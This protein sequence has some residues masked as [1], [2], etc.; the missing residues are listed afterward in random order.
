MEVATEIYSLIDLYQH[1]PESAFSKL[2]KMGCHSVELYGDPVL[3]AMQ[4]AQLLS[5]YHLNLTSWQVEWRY[6]QQ[7]NLNYTLAYHQQL[8]T[9]TLIIPALGGP[10]E[11]GHTQTQNTAAMWRKHCEWITQL[12]P[13]VEQAGIEFGYHTHDYDFGQKLDTGETSLEIILANTP[14]TFQIEVDTGNAIEGG[15]IPEK[16]IQQLP[17]RVSLIHCKPFSKQRRYDL[18][19]GDSDDQN[20]WHQIIQ[21]CQKA[22]TQY[23]ICETE[24]STIAVPAQIAQ[25]DYQKLNQMIVG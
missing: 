21:A 18:F 16:L 14:K 15:L 24:A 8:Q 7:Q 23:L 6:L 13:L 9:P 20:H 25:A 17:G 12:V 1:D 11:V 19:L 2:A 4:M 5:K 10:W 3:P 22:G